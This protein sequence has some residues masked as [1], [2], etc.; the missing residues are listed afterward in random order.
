MGQ[1]VVLIAAKS[2][3]LTA[4]AGIICSRNKKTSLSNSPAELT[5]PAFSQLHVSFLICHNLIHLTDI[6]LPPSYNF[7]SLYFMHSIQHSGVINCRGGV[8]LRGP[9]SEI[10]EQDTRL[11]LGY[12]PPSIFF[13]MH[14]W[15]NY[16][17]FF[18]EK[19]ILLLFRRF[20][21]LSKKNLFHYKA[22]FLYDFKKLAI[23]FHSHSTA[24]LP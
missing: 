5:I 8:I 11:P 15:K 19:V 18:G 17:R 3:W 24:N 9:I 7:N 10:D 13:E 2:S 20:A 4:P 21:F 14:F 22:L 12:F 23:L 16:P 1:T 6:T